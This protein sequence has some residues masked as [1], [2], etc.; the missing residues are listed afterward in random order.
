[1]SNENLTKNQEFVNKNLEKLLNLYKNKYILV[2]KQEVVGSFDTYE[3]AAEEGIKAYGIDGSFLV[4]YV[5]ETNPVNF[6]SA[7]IL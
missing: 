5:T 1:M 3:V 6:I 2:Y 7:A 4:H